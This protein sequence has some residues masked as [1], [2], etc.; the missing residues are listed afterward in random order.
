MLKEQSVKS[1]DNVNNCDDA[2]VI[3]II[4]DNFHGLSFVRFSSSPESYPHFSLTT[5]A[6]QLFLKYIYFLAYGHYVPV[7][8]FIYFLFFQRSTFSCAKIFYIYIKK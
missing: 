7:F 1:A 5:A 4:L 8:A 3:H 6:T 2:A